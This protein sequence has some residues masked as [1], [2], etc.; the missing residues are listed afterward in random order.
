MNTPSDHT[1]EQLARKALTEVL[2]MAYSGELAAANAYRGHWISVRDAQEKKDIFQIEIEELQHRQDV[3]MMLDSLGAK[4]L[5]RREILMNM[6]G[7]GI[8]FLCLIGGWFIPMYGA[9]KIE[10]SNIQEY[11]RAAQYA[12]I[13]KHL[14]WVDP[15]LEMAELEWDHEQYFYQKVKGHFLNKWITPWREPEPKINI[16]ERFAAFCHEQENF[17]ATTKVIHF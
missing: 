17:H 16:R 8:G 3:G 9:G 10:A 2:Q 12:H 13:A 5:F 4:P 7:R 14:D 6:I 15:L 11:E 1:A